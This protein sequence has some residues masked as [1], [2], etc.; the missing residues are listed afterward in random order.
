MIKILTLSISLIFVGIWIFRKFR[1]VKI[2]EIKHVP[3]GVSK[4][5]YLVVG[6]FLFIGPLLLSTGGTGLLNSFNQETRW[7]KTTA[8]VIELK[9]A[10]QRK[11]RDLYK[12]VVKFQDV[13]ETEVIA[14]TS[15]ETA[16][17]PQPGANLVIRYNPSKPTEAVNDDPLLRWGTSTLLFV[18][19]GF[20]LFFAGG[21]AVQVFRLQNQE[22]VFR[23]T[24]KQVIK[25][26]L[27]EVK[28]NFFL[29]LRH[30]DSWRLIVEYKDSAGRTYKTESEPI[31]KYH[32]DGW[33]KKDIPVPVVIDPLQYENSW[34]LVQDYFLACKGT[35]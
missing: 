9:K 3:V 32:P 2:E 11:G 4:W 30:A 23:N 29:S 1:Q 33:S 21:A 35:K 7:T 27:L 19:G 14:T 20:L 13:A 5:T 26:R 15:P 28:K 10:G 18:I 34:I 6:L 12:A 16:S 31:W 22:K 24:Q 25:G 8:Q 17:P